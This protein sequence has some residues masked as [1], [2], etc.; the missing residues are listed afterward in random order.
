MMSRLG[1]VTSEA[2]FPLRILE[3]YPTENPDLP[4]HIQGKGTNF[5]YI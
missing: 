1:E 4:E 2:P 5:S 3:I